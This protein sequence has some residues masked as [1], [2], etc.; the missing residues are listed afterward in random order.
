MLIIIGALF[1]LP[2]VG[3]QLGKNLNVVGWLI[4]RPIDAVIGAI[5]Q[6]TGN[7]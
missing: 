6:V 7:S 1:I 3:A 4:G 2:M 5:L